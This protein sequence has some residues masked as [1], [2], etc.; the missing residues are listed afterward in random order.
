MK[1]IKRGRGCA[2]YT[3]DTLGKYACRIDLFSRG[4]EVVETCGKFETPS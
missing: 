4:V 2:G 1:K 3:F